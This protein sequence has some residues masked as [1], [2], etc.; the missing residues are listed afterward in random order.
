M[1]KIGDQFLADK[2]SS[3]DQTS[4]MFFKTIMRAGKKI[5]SE[6]GFL[7]KSKILLDGV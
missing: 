3:Y 2:L 1:A 7:A 4:C 6:I 5:K